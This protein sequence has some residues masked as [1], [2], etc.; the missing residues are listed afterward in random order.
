M[1]TDTNTSLI[2][3]VLTNGSKISIYTGKLVEA[4]DDSNTEKRTHL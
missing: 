2:H 3:K 1:M 4:L